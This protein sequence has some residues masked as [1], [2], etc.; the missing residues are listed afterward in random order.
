MKPLI[1]PVHH[2]VQD[3]MKLFA[4]VADHMQDRKA[5]AARPATAAKQ[6]TAASPPR[7]RRTILAPQE[8]RD[9]V[10]ARYAEYR[11]AQTDVTALSR[12][13]GFTTE[14]R[15]A[16]CACY[17]GNDELDKLKTAILDAQP[18]EFGFKCPYCGIATIGDMWDHYLP[19][20]LKDFPE[21][22]ILPDNLIPSCGRCNVLK[23]TVTREQG[24]R[25]FVHFYYDR[26]NPSDCYLEVTFSFPN[27][28]DDLPRATFALKKDVSTSTFGALYARHC[29][30]LGLLPLYD[31]HARAYIRGVPGELRKRG[32]TGPEEETA[33]AIDELADDLVRLHGAN[34]AKAALYRAAARSPEFIAYCRR[35]SHD[36]HH[37]S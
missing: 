13:P 28:A 27:T 17:A 14:Q 20:N 31:K 26:F 1:L 9:R 29:G 23:G 22:S 8:L 33:D 19:Q 12:D 32:R 36:H 5:I 16:L 7:L 6:A 24:Q 10:A 4:S 3:S 15:E 21:F 18:A 37:S 11:A 30:K 25:T 2:Y 35:P 34:Y